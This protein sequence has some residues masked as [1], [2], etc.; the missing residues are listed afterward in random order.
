VELFAEGTAEQVDNFLKALAHRMADY[1][2]RI[3]IQEMA[4]EGFKGFDIR[5]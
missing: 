4:P 5:Y 3:N 2:S 1:I